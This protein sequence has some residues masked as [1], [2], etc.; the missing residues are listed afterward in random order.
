[1]S[2]LSISLFGAP[3]IENDG[4]ALKINRRKAVALLAYL[5]ITQQS[6]SRDALATMFWPEADQSHARAALR[7][8]LWVLNKTALKEWLLVEPEMVQL[9]SETSEE[10]SASSSEKTLNIDVIRFR[11]LLT[12]SQS[13]QHSATALCADCVEHLTQAVSLYKNEFMAGFTLPD[14][15]EFDEWQFFQANSLR[16][17]L[18]T[19]LENLIAYHRGLGD[20]SDAI[21]YARRY[22]AL[23]LLHEPAHQT[24]MQLYAQAGQRSAAL[25]QYEICRQTLESELGLE[26]SEETHRLYERVYS[27]DWKTSAIKDAKTAVTSTT[28]IDLPPQNIIPHNLPPDPTPLIGRKHER[29]ELATFLDDRSTRLLTITGPGGIGKS[30][31][32]LAA[33]ADQLPKAKYA[34]GVYF[35]ALAPL[36]E[37]EA[38]IPAISEAIGYP[39]QMDQRTPRQQIFDYLSKKSMLI[40]LD[41]VEHL[42]LENQSDAATFV[43]ELLQ[44]APHLKILATSREQLNLYEEQRYPIHGLTVADSSEETGSEYAAAKLF[45]QTVRRRRPDFEIT[46][47]DMSCLAD[48]CRLVEGMPLALELAASWIE[49][50]SLREIAARIQQNLGFLETNVRNVPTRHRSIQAVFDTSWQSL[51]ESERRIYAQLSVFRGGFTH[52]AAEA[53]AE[54]SLPTLAGL[55]NKSLL[56]FNQGQNRYENHELLR[57]YAAEKLA[58]A[59]EETSNRHTVFYCAFLNQCESGLKGPQQQEVLAAIEADGEN[60]RGAW[61]WAAVHAQVANLEKSLDALALFYQ[62]R[63][64]YG[65]GAE[66]CKT[67]VSQLDRIPP[68]QLTE[69]QA[70]LLAKLFTWQG[71]FYIALTRYDDARQ[72]L[73]QAQAV[74]NIPNLQE[75]DISAIN[76]FLFLQ[77]SHFSIVND[78][79]GEALSLNEESLALFKSIDDAWGTAVALDALSQKNM[80]IGLHEKAIQQQEECLAIRQQLGDQRGIAQSHNV[81]G[82]QVLHVGQIEKSEA[83]LRE[84]LGIFRTM[85]NQAL[86]SKPLA[87]L[88]INLLFGGKFDDCIASYEECWAVHK[89]L[90]ISQEP[91]TANAGMTRAK[92]NLGRY[93]EARMQ[94]QKQLIEYRSINHWWNTAF[95]LFNLGRI[96]LVEGEAEQAERHLQESAGILQKMNERSLLPDVLFCQAFTSR[97]LNNRQ[98]AIDYMIQ[99]LKIVIE[100]EPLN[101]MRFELPCMALLLADQGEVEQAVE[102]Y[103]A[104]LQSVYIAN[105]RWFEDIAGRHITEI[106]TTLP[107]N[108]IVAAQNRGNA[109]NLWTTANALLDKLQMKSKN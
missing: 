47:A 32:A 28:F 51:R 15:L 42:L 59:R 54:A 18:V 102:F 29:T 82:L 24:L 77:L 37:P 88:G 79:G 45:L 109:R 50:L 81:L 16:Q 92:I 2:Q 11:N 93:D 35:V 80:N 21:P 100:T 39:F 87:V 74:L 4:K 84:S 20:F 38:V 19:S 9:R 97:A 91:Y 10:H 64:R 49:L 61:Q 103:A 55:V 65:D 62:W 108:V 44:R 5:A 25:R 30:R 26:P 86:I 90:G 40:L 105:S 1:M 31:L 83:Y 48:I 23:D 46:P 96:G 94:A 101:P 17:D 72:A 12:T 99:S 57:Q 53:V 33:A 6:H 63:S 8:A 41:N 73:K 7:S 3:Q 60:V 13:H 66:M 98:Q 56:R 67:A 95:T 68:E 85:N 70:R 27:G 34:D 107:K 89:E 76:A 43:A 36:S 106:A 22:V 75:Q 78:F 104:G 71:A 58:D 14:A 52:E 69:T